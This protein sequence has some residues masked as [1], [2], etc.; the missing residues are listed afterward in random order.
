MDRQQRN[1]VVHTFYCL[2]IGNEVT[3]G[4]WVKMTMT[5]NLTNTSAHWWYIRWH[6]LV[7]ALVDE[8]AEF[9]VKSLLHR[10]PMQL[11][12]NCCRNLV[13]LPLLNKRTGLDEDGLHQCH[14]KH[15]CKNQHDFDECINKCLR[16][17]GVEWRLDWAKLPKLVETSPG[18][19][20]DVKGEL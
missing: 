18:E 5:L 10:Q 13:V 17:I 20:P 6:T 3:T 7:K 12:L 11:I 4:C 2:F 1:C 14:W 8:F 19:T 16:C 15:Y 9:V